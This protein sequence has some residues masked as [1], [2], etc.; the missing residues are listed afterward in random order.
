MLAKPYFTDKITVSTNVAASMSANGSLVAKDFPCRYEEGGSSTLP[1]WAEEPP[2]FQAIGSLFFTLGAEKLLLKFYP[3]A[4]FLTTIFFLH[5]IAR[6]FISDFAKYRNLLLVMIM[7]QPYIILHS[8]RSIPDN[9]ALMFLVI[10][11]YFH[12]KQKIKSAFTFALLAVTT[13]A[14]AI[15]PIFFLCVGNLLFKKEH[16]ISKRFGVGTLYGLSI[17]PM[18]L[19]LYYLYDRQILNPFFP[20]N[21]FELTTHTGGS[22]Y[23]FLFMK[24]FWSRILSWVVIRGISIPYFLLTLY[25][26]YKKIKEKNKLESIDKISFTILGG[27]I[28]YILMVREP[29]LSAP[30][31]SFYFLPFYLIVI[32]RNFAIY[33]LRVLTVS[34]IISVIS[35]ISMVKWNLNIADN[36]FVQINT[37]AADIH[38][39]FHEFH[40]RSSAEKRL[41]ALKK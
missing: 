11:L 4:C 9:L 16:S 38:C 21:S 27:H 32:F 8:A 2:V 6:E 22:S 25:A 29:Q 37:Q 13:K 15:F 19:W 36:T 34:I 18:L 31:Y 14:L 41:R 33:N 40:K 26:T 7:G 10:F 23:Y 35:G 12:L 1:T 5:L 20:T 24:K 28:I 17:I 30:W 3:V 39:N